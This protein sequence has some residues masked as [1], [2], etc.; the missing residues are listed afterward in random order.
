METQTITAVFDHLAEAESA[1]GRLEVAGIPVTDIAVHRNDPPEAGRPL[2]DET[3]VTACVETPLIDKAMG[4]MTG[5][6]RI[7]DTIESR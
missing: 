6:G 7:E 2:T 1:V 5:D 3:I 4:I